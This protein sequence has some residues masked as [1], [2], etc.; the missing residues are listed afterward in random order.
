MFAIYTPRGRSFFGPLE[1]LRGVDKTDAVQPVRSSTEKEDQQVHYS[2]SQQAA[3]Q[4]VQQLEQEGERE[5][6]YHAYQIMSKQVQSLR[7]NDSLIEA[8]RL[9]EQFRF[10]LFPIVDE[11]NKLCG[12]LSRQA[13]YHAMIYS[14]LKQALSHKTIG[15]HFLNAQTQVYGADP[16][17]DVRRIATLLVEKNLDALPIIEE[18]GLIVGLVSRTDILRAAIADP[19]LSLWC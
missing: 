16:V 1:Q 3:Q 7:S 12:S 6:V 9:F 11:Q 17:T 8:S 5:P 14:D 13:F 18:S 15:S 2:V 4:Y 10:Q 19:P